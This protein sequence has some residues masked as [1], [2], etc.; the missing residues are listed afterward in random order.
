MPPNTAGYLALAVLLITLTRIVAG[1]IY[2]FIKRPPSVQPHD[3]YTIP[4]DY[5]NEHD[6][7]NLD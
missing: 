3:A 4:G 7:D 1:Y 6:N 5:A 2:F